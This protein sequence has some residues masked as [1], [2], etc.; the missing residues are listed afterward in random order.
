MAVWVAAATVAAAWFGVGWARAAWF[1]DVPREHARESA[2]DAAQQA[3]INLASMNP[4]NVD[5]SINLMR[6]SMTGSMRD[7]LDENRQRIKDAAQQSKTRIEAKVLG[8][9]LSS[10][11]SERQHASAVVVLRQVQSAPGA[12]PRTFRATWT[13]DMDNGGGVW[14]AA[15]ANS[16]GNLVPLDL[17]APTAGSPAAGNAP[18]AGGAAQQ[19]SS[20]PRAAGP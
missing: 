18:S 19:P 12:P 3:A 5:G 10:L 8:A 17:P 1:T 9:A 4:D 20:A 13:L 2:L 7:Q 15:Q 16:I 11:D 6:S 14:R